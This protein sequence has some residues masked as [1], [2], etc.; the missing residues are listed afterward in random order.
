M[1][2]LGRALDPLKRR[3]MLMVGRA[4][5]EYINDATKMQSA[6]VSLLEG[7]VREKVEHFQSYGFTSVAEPG[8]EGVALSVSGSRDHV[9][10]ICVD[11]RRYR[12]K[13]MLPGETAVY[14]KWGDF[15]LLKEAEIEVVHQTKIT[16]RAPLVVLDAAQTQVTGNMQ[17][18]GT[19]T[20]TVDVVGAGKSLKNHIHSGVT[21]GGGNTGAPV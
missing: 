1:S 15:I 6:Q 10:L 14:T 4:V 9:I 8:A 11:D 5:V 2:A 3:V 17:V 7:E 19:V 13:G 16:H 12:M 21:T 18:G 20:V